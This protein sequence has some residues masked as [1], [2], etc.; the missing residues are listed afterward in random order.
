M[1]EPAPDEWTLVEAAHLFQR[2]GFSGT[3]PQIVELH[4]RGRSG[5][6][7]WLLAVEGAELPEVPLWARPEA[8]QLARE[9]FRR[10][11]GELRRQ[12]N[13]AG[14][15]TPERERIEGLL[16]DL[17]NRQDR[18]NQLQASESVEWWFRRMC[19]SPGGLREQMT[20]FWH[21]HFATG[22]DKVRNPALMLWQNQLLRRHSLGNFRAL[23]QDVAR[24]P[25]MVVYLDLGQSDKDH[26]NENF[27][28]ELMELFVLG[29][30][31]GYT[32]ADILEAARALTGFSL[33]RSSGLTQFDPRRHDD[34]EKTLFGRRASFAPAQ[35]IDLIIEQ[36]AMAPHIAGKIWNWFAGDAP[37]ETL[38]PFLGL[39]L[40]RGGLE[41]VPFLRTLF[42]SRE[43]YHPQVM[44]RRI[45][46]PLQLLASFCRQFGIPSI[47]RDYL[48]GVLS[49]LDHLPFLPP[50]VAGWEGGRSWINGDSLLTRYN[51]IGELLE[52]GFRG[53]AFRGRMGNAFQV[54]NVQRGMRDWSGPQWR[55]F[56][57]VEHRQDRE[58]VLD[59]L[60]FLFFGDPLAEVRREELRSW[61]EQAEG[62]A[63]TTAE[64]AHLCELLCCTPQ[65][66]LG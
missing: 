19:S 10:E 60:L 38:K 51:V 43:F 18:T 46:S 4:G 29:E 59:I 12:R 9:E 54:R 40:Q 39:E 53:P 26:P 36:P 41:I 13:E 31:Q 11:V 58:G 27:A 8:V 33:D 17:N 24:D 3:Y 42:T 61:L 14:E 64:L 57:P 7:N 16:R 32:E 52:P 20:L 37:G 50:N 30:G 28:R 35:A 63:V 23:V 1:L 5:A 65:Y 25:A 49:K 66:Q 22:I 15:G 47:P 55:R 44:Q 48:V 34:G 45:K 62:V 6:V 56:L 21:D 2:A